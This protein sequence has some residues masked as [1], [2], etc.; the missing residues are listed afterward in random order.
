[1]QATPAHADIVLRVGLGRIAR[2]VRQRGDNLML[3]ILETAIRTLDVRLGQH[4]EGGP[5]AAPWLAAGLEVERRL[6]SLNGRRKAVRLERSFW[7]QLDTIA[8]Q[9]GVTAETLCSLIDRACG[10]E[11]LA[12]ALRVFVLFYVNEGNSS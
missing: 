2:D 5:L 1:M 7:H 11:A 6:I 3:A 9:S 12:S 4:S 8:A 10:G